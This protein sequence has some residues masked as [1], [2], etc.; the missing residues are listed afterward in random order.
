M[1][2]T[3]RCPDRSTATER[4]EVE[5]VW[6]CTYGSGDPDDDDALPPYT[7]TDET[8][9]VLIHHGTGEVDVEATVEPAAQDGPD[10]DDGLVDEEQPAPATGAPAPERARGTA[11]VPG[12]PG[13]GNAPPPW[14]RLPGVESAPY[15]EAAPTV[16][17]DSDDVVGLTAG[18][19]SP[20]AGH[21]SLPPD[22]GP[23]PLGHG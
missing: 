7:E 11:R 10:E 17:T 9:A 4:I 15:L 6:R 22:A 20:R 12:A 3:S 21:G 13:R 8:G 16:F 18:V 14:G 5:E 2:L 1:Y 23:S 19:P